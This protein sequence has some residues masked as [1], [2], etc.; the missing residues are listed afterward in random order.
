MSGQVTIRKV[1]NQ[2]DFKTFFEFPWKHY[3]DDPNWVPPLLSMRQELLD[4]E[5]NPAWDYMEGDYFLALRGEE[6]VGTIAAFINHRHNEFHGE[7]IGWFGAFE[8]RDDP[9][10]AAALLQMAEDWVRDQ[11]Y[12]IIR[13]PQTFTTHE[14]VGLLIDGFEQP[15]LLMPYHHRYYRGFIE[16]AG[17]AA[18]SDTG[19]YYYDWSMVAENKLMDRL[20]KI[21]QW[22]AKRHNVEVRPVDSKNLRKEFELFKELYNTA[23]VANW[24]FVPMT[25][26]EL[27]SLIEG[28]GM[29]FDPDLACFATYA[30]KPIGFTMLVPD[31][32]QALKY[33]RPRPGVPE[34]W[35]LLQILWHW[36]LR[37]K[38]NRVR[39]PLMGVIEEYRKK[40]LDV[41][42][43]DYCIRQLRKKGMQTL[44][45]GWI[46]DTNEDMIG[47]LKGLGMKRHRSYR[48]YEKALDPKA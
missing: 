15:F 6:A 42:M 31:F 20:E 4:K 40:G 27:D 14:E 10:V 29:I 45:C 26:R 9:E 11:G 18:S 16:N 5:K 32:N 33:A 36:K 19:S 3:K 23:W 28:M 24:G 13:G 46:L 12:T 7:A 41:V 44:D 38:I 8:T 25:E 2:Q 21:A 35:T 48:L 1:E 30:G 37:P 22:T 34:P 39:V 47:V 17:Y 43:Y